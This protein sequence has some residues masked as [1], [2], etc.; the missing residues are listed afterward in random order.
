[1]FLFSTGSPR[2]ASPWGAHP[3]KGAPGMVSLGRDGWCSSP[4]LQ[5]VFSEEKSSPLAQE[6][7][8]LLSAPSG[9][10]HKG[11]GVAQWFCNDLQG[12]KRYKCYRFYYNFQSFCFPCIIS[13]PVFFLF[14]CGFRGFCFDVVL[15]VSSGTPEWTALLPLWL[16]M[17][18]KAKKPQENS[19]CR[20]NK[21][22]ELTKQITGCPSAWN[23]LSKHFQK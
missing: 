2:T 15:C 11:F 12:G 3:G 21:S 6:V 14:W 1:M 16:T 13:W 19:F 8:G 9:C 17:R 20:S 18:R 5:E 22:L 4:W 7:S 10:P 23:F